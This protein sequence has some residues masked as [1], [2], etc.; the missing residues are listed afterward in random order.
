[1]SGR[2]TFARTPTA[3]RFLSL[4]ETESQQIIN[5]QRL[6]NGKAKN[7]R[8]FAS[9]THRTSQRSGRAIAPKIMTL[10][11]SLSIALKEWH[12]VSRALASGRQIILLRKG[13][14]SESIGGFEL[15]HSQFLLFPTFLHQNLQMLKP[16]V[17]EQYQ[18]HSAEPAKIEISLAAE[19]SD[20]VRLE[21]RQQMDALDAQHIWTQ[22]LIDMRFNYRPSN[23]LYLLLLRAYRLRQTV[24][25]ANTP[26]YAG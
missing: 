16:E 12:I 24:T 7:F 19:V 23:P 3:Q 26:E 14:I 10:H 8:Q 25:I 9:A 4:I 18:P 13:G 17:H 2:T 20:I 22:P 21:N 11:N 15:E 6:V 1:M 5:F